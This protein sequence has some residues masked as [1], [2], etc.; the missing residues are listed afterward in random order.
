MAESEIV[1]DDFYEFNIDVITHH[2]IRL[3]IWSPQ[4]PDFKVGVD[5]ILNGVLV[6]QYTANNYRADLIQHGKGNGQYAL[7]ISISDV[8]SHY[9]PNS[10]LFLELY[11]STPKRYLLVSKQLTGGTIEFEKI[12]PAKLQRC[13]IA[14]APL[15]LK[16]RRLLNTSAFWI[17]SPSDDTYINRIFMPPNSLSDKETAAVSGGK[18]CISSYSDYV[19]YRFK[20]DNVFPVHLGI[21]EALHY[22][23]WYLESYCSMRKDLRAPLFSSRDWIT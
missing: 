22:T 13:K 14:L 9:I 11:A 23:K 18:F 5:L 17:D 6:G 1:E 16:A 2:D 12:D 15:S 10:P 8:T 3:W 21:S 19:R 4:N 20:V 7:E